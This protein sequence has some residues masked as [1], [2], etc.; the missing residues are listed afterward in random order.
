MGETSSTSRSRKEVWAKWAFT[1]MYSTNPTN[2][3]SVSVLVTL[4]PGRVDVA[5][6]M[7]R[8]ILPDSAL[9][10][11]KVGTLA[12]PFAKSTAALASTMP[13]PYSWLKL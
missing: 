9:I 3:W 10:F 12:Q 11:R 7:V 1:S 2:G 8:L 6:G 13:K 4:A 5:S